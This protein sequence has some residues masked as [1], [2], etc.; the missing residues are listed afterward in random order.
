[1]LFMTERYDRNENILGTAQC[2]RYALQFKP[3]QFKKGIRA[4]CAFLNASNNKGDAPGRKEWETSE[5]VVR[6]WEK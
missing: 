5:L 3:S 2:L 6:L 1:M 4:T